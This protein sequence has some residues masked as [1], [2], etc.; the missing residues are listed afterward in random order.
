MKIK[1]KR[2]AGKILGRDGISERIIAIAK[3]ISEGSYKQAVIGGGQISQL[4][5]ACSFD[6]Y[7]NEKAN[8]GKD[9]EQCEMEILIN[10]RKVMYTK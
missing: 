3:E 4:I 1:D 6:E 7:W 9:K 2:E 5:D 10:K 8:I